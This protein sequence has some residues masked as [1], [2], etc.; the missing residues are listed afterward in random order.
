MNFVELND[1]IIVCG[2]KKKY[3]Q[4]FILIIQLLVLAYKF[5]ET[6]VAVLGTQLNVSR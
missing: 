2:H 4:W 1:L 5:L 6:Y 3:I